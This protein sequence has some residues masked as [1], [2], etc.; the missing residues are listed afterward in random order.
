MPFRTLV[1]QYQNPA[2]P[3]QI[4]AV[5][6]RHS[7]GGAEKGGKTISQK[8]LALRREVERTRRARE[9]AERIKR[10]A[11]LAERTRRGVWRLRS[12]AN[13]LPEHKPAIQRLINQIRAGSND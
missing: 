1:S 11:A 2:P 9:E 10:E 8:R 3:L 5:A 7:L 13:F 4:G 6:V 12:L